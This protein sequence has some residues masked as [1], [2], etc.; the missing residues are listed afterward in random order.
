MTLPATCAFY[1]IVT[2]LAALQLQGTAR[3]NV[4]AAMAINALVV[5]GALTQ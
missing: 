3:V 1:L 5:A 2:L 4:L